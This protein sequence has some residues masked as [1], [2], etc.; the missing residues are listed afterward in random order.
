[1][2]LIIQ[3]GYVDTHIEKYLDENY[4]I[5]K[6]FDTDVSQLD[7]TRYSTVII[8]G[9]H[10]SILKLSQYD[11]LNSVIVLIQNCL[12]I[13]K[14]TLG[15][16]LGGQLIAYTI[17]CRIDTL[18]ERRIGFD[19]EIL[20]HKHIF[21]CH[22]DYVIPNEKLECIE[23]FKDIPYVF[24]HENLVGIQFHP[25]IPPE[26]VFKYCPDVSIPPEAEQID[27]SNKNIVEYL[28]RLL[29]N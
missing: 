27:E 25:D 26:T 22:Q 8:L 14:P 3:N 17:G 29:K 19:T 18:S 11:Y 4:E 9:G 23:L 12:S 5:I 13:K 2:I 24:R 20:G 28:F 7:I 15:I 1:M 16:C 21:R 6:S 10:Q